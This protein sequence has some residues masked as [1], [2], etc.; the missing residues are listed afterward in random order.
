[1]YEIEDQ[2]IQKYENLLLKA[3]QY[4]KPE[5]EMTIFDTALNNHH[6]NPITELLAFFLNPNEKHGMGSSF[7]NGF[8]EAIK[9]LTEDKL[10]NIVK[11]DNEVLS[12]AMKYFESLNISFLVPL[13]VLFGVYITYDEC[14]A[15]L[16]RSLLS[17]LSLYL[18]S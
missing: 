14:G 1:M 11:L 8:I 15:P 3:Q 9:N 18:S 16:P 7:Y 13:L 17:L 12:E 5:R 6:E 10:K 2:L 4:K